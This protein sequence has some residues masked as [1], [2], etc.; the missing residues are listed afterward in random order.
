MLEGFLAAR[1]KMA[2]TTETYQ[3]VVHVLLSMLEK[4]SEM[5][6]QLAST[7]S[8]PQAAP[9]VNNFV[10]LVKSEQEQL[11]R[12]AKQIKER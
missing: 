3:H 1:E 10:H 9:I 2:T 4:H 5:V 8:S 11:S 7:R 12:L 6:Y